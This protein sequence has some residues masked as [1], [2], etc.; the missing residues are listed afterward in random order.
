[1]NQARQA[2]EPH[3]GAHSSPTISEAAPPL[4]AS[5][6]TEAEAIAAALTALKAGAP[7]AGG[8]SAGGEARQSGAQAQA[9]TQAKPVEPAKKVESTA[10][11][12]AELDSLIGLGAVKAQVRSVIAVV[13]A[14]TERT[15]AGLVA[16]NPS[17]HLVFTG[18]PGT[19]KTTV[20]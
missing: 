10:D 4:R 16:V 9:A 15:K 5:F 6:N 1:M 12:L 20:A 17:L 13:Q 2:L 3:G 8:E 7:P 18:P 14:N 11:I 19:G